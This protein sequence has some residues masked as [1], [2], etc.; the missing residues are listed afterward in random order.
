V[1]SIR[2]GMALAQVSKLTGVPI[3][4]L[5]AKFRMKAGRGHSLPRPNGRSTYGSAPSAPPQAGEAVE[6]KNGSSGSV[7]EPNVSL[8]QIPAARERAERHILGILLSEPHRWHDVQ[9]R[10]H[11]ED[12]L[13]PQHARIAGVYWSHQRDEGEPVF[14]QFLDLLEDGGLTTLAI[15][16]VEEI[17]GLVRE[18]DAVDDQHTIVE[19]TLAAAID[20]LMTVRHDQEQ[21]KLLASLR[22]TSEDNGPAGPDA[23][24]LFEA[25]VKNNQATN[26]RRLGPIKRSR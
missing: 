12:F 15:E 20:Y 11:A 25:L 24:E 23:N 21:Q 6:P 10:V 19:Q 7:A 13:N 14:N 5:N 3:D 8:T 17:E 16:L 26:L 2:W 4:E 18:L 9:V 1:D 22:R